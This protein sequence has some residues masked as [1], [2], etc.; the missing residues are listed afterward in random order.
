[1]TKKEWSFQVDYNQSSIVQYIDH[2]GKIRP[3][4]NNLC[5]GYVHILV[6]QNALENILIDGFLKKLQVLNQVQMSVD[7][8]QREPN[9]Q[10]NYNLDSGV[11]YLFNN[12]TYLQ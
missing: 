7:M 12:K 10:I 8:G 2:F 11:H 1:M 5:G 6:N 9:F 4:F 3:N